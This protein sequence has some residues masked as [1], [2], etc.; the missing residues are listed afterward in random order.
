M[1][2]S[3]PRTVSR[4]LANNRQA[5]QLNMRPVENEQGIV[6][7]GWARVW[8]RRMVCFFWYARTHARMHTHYGSARCRKE[9]SGKQL[10][11]KPKDH[12]ICRSKD[13]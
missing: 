8:M 9:G 11:N 1:S 12:K 5:T 13:N 2:I 7:E 10:Y 4:Q 6:D 3:M